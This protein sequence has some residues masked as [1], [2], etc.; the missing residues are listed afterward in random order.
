MS[1]DY[2]MSVSTQMLAQ[3]GRSDVIEI[4]AQVSP[5]TFFAT[6]FLGR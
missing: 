5:I 6:G 2:L 3:L 4:L 1:G